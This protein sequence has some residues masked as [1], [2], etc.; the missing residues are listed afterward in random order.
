[1]FVFLPYEIIFICILKAIVPQKKHFILLRSNF[2]M[3]STFLI[4]LYL[5]QIAN[6]SFFNRILVRKETLYIVHIISKEES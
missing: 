4:V 2:H 5:L 1:M 6:A 3:I